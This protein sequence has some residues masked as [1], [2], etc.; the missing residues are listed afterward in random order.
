MK[1]VQ[2]TNLDSLV[3][4]GLGAN[5]GDPAQTLVDAVKQIAQEA[6]ITL[7]QSASLYQSA[8]VDAPGPHYVNTAVLIRT[9]LRPSEL[10]QRTQAIEHAFG[11]QRSVR[12]APRTLDIDLLWHEHLQS[13]ATELI[14]PH[15]RLHQR[16]FVLKPLIELLGPDFIVQQQTAQHWLSLCQDQV[17][18]KIPSTI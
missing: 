8:P 10:L 13:D 2:H 17:C 15:P 18:E 5:L 3:L 14:L 16:A 12:N 9:T 1:T 4:L 7:I 11:R 6:G